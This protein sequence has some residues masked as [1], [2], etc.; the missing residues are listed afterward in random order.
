MS[1]SVYS[2]LSRKPST[3]ARI[4]TSRELC[5]C[6]TNSKATGVSCGATVTTVTLGRAGGGAAEGLLQPNSRATTAP[7][8]ASRHRCGHG[9]RHETAGITGQEEHDITDTSISNST[10]GFYLR[11]AP[12]TVSIHPCANTPVVPCTPAHHWC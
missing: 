5:V 6:A 8:A 10:H 4:S 1:P 12:G 2:R 9:D 3:R 7:M 11:D